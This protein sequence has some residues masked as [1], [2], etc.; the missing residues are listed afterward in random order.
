MEASGESAYKNI[1]Q[2][3]Q[4]KQI[5]LK[6]NAYLSVICIS[7]YKILMRDTE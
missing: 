7:I 6:L 4:H 3:R 2:K 5:R 1:R